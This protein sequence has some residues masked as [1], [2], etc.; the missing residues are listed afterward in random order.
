VKKF[1]FDETCA[2]IM[3]QMMTSTVFGLGAQTN[4]GGAV[5]GGS[6]FYATGDT[7]IPKA[8]GAKRGKRGRIQRRA[9]ITTT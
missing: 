8:L 2:Q 1:K 5:P 9:P 7:R 3:E 6:D 4:Q